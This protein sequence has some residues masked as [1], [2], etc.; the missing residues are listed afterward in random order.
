M[1]W[2]HLG[3]GVVARVTEQLTF[4]GEQSKCSLSLPEKKMFTR[5]TENK[6]TNTN[7]KKPSGVLIIL[8]A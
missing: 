8:G 3:N 5:K 4:I 2:G 1:A 6:Q 7:K